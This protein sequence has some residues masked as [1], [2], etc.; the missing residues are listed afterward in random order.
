MCCNSG[1]PINL[2]GVADGAIPANGGFGSPITTIG[3]KAGG[4][5]GFNGYISAIDIYSGVLTPTEISQVEAQ[6]TA[7]YITVPEPATWG[8]LATGLGTLIAVRR[9]RRP[10]A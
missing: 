2:N 1:L 7:S 8:M 6:L 5:E 3:N 10:Q 4:D 9:F